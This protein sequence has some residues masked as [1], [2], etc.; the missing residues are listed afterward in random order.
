VG[1]P[2][3]LL[4]YSRLLVGAA[5]PDRQV[6]RKEND[7]CDTADTSC[8]LELNSETICVQRSV[9]PYLIGMGCVVLFAL[10]TRIL[11]P[12]VGR[13]VRRTAVKTAFSATEMTRRYPQAVVS[14]PMRSDALA[15]PH[16]ERPGDGHTVQSLWTLGSCVTRAA[17]VAS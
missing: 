16:T 8:R 12:A 2:R 13:S 1:G 3:V 7:S 15:S 9:L 5:D 11:A 6:S 14:S 10:N 4:D 17:C